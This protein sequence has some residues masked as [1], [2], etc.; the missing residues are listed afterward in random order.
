MYFTNGWRMYLYKLQSAIHWY[1]WHYYWYQSNVFLH[2]LKPM[3]EWQSIDTNHTKVLM[4]EENA[5]LHSLKPWENVLSI[6]MRCISPM[7]YQWN[8]WYCIGTNRTNGQV[9]YTPHLAWRQRKYCKSA[10]MRCISPIEYQWNKR[11]S[12]GT[13]RTNEQVECTPTQPKAKRNILSPHNEMQFT[14]GIPVE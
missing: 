6:H 7:E 2:R 5:P 12:I 9:E 14:N 4:V 13:N 3:A 10:V 1:Q 11:F 8:R